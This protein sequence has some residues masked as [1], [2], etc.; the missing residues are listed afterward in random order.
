MIATAVGGSPAAATGSAAGRRPTTSVISAS[1][2]QAVLGR[3][4]IERRRCRGRRTR[5]RDP[6]AAACRSCSPPR[7]AAGAAPRRRSSSVRSSGLS[8]AR[9]STTTMTA[10]A[11]SAASSAW[12]RTA[13]PSVF[14]L[15]GLEAAGV[16]HQEAAAVALG[17]GDV[18]V[19]RHP[20]R[21]R[22][23]GAARARQ[24]VEERRLAG[25]RPPDQ[26]DDGQPR[27]LLGARQSRRAG[28]AACGLWLMAHGR[29][30]SDTP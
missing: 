2:P 30:T 10:S 13:R 3:D 25:V 5:R 29:T 6:R 26:R 12:A 8:P 16:D 27:E 18:A 9:P 19:A 20:R 11:A 7:T 23:Q 15:V 22:H 1:T 17:D 24:P 21:R 4:R 14:V 28:G